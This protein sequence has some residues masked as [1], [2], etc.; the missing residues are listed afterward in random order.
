MAPKKEGGNSKK[1]TAGASHD[2][3]WVPSLMGDT[4]LNEMVEAGILPDRVTVGWRPADDEPIR[5]HTMMSLLYL[6][7]I[8][9]MD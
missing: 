8:S 2:K 6:K 3:E 9:G 4:E 7:T 1:A 5:C